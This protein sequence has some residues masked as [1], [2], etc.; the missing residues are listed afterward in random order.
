[1]GT[2]CGEGDH[3]RRDALELNVRGPHIWRREDAGTHV[4]DAQSRSEMYVEFD[5][6]DPIV[7][8]MWDS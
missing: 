6:H 4:R 1:M 7:R 3:A 8:A 5:G 2:T